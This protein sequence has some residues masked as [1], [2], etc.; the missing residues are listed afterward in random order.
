MKKRRGPARA[1]NLLVAETATEPQAS[2]QHRRSSRRF[3]ARTGPGRR[4]GGALECDRVHTRGD[5][6]SACHGAEAIRRRDADWPDRCSSP[7]V[8]SINDPR[9]KENAQI[10][11]HARSRRSLYVAP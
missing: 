5:P 3:N 11:L 7:F 9:T 2:T 1:A 6:G 4:F 10:T 8:D